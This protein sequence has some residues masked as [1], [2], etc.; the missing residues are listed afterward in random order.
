MDSL[1]IF[2]SLLLHG[3]STRNL[4]RWKGTVPD[5]LEA[6]VPDMILVLPSRWTLRRE[7]GPEASILQVQIS[8][9]SKDP[10]PTF[11]AGS[12]WLP[13]H[14]QAVISWRHWCSSSSFLTGLWMRKC[15]ARASSCIMISW[16]HLVEDTALPLQFILG[17]FLRHQA[18]ACSSSFCS[19]FM[20]S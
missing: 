11:P 20:S 5:S 15:G 3:R 12:S 14:C 9:C 17:S 4:E 7:S 8:R 1:Y 16:F 10:K 2:S 6:R 18:R 19:H 13:R